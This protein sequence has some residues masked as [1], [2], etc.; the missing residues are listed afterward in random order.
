MTA[1]FTMYNKQQ[2][3]SVRQSAGALSME[4]L[5]ILSSQ[6]HVAFPSLTATLLV[7]I[8]RAT[9]LWTELTAHFRDSRVV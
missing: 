3:V 6:L 4:L 9:V 1:H 2:H 5:H 8:E 7:A